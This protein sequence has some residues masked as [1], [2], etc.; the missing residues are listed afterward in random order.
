MKLENSDHLSESWHFLQ[1]SEEQGSGFDR[2]HL[3]LFGTDVGSLRGFAGTETDGKREGAPRS[4]SSSIMPNGSPQR[5]LEGDC[6]I[7]FAAC[8][9]HVRRR[10]GWLGIFFENL[11]TSHATDL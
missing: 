11:N 5:H 2:S 8:R 7:C 4:T 3:P 1:C 10:L 9:D 6:E